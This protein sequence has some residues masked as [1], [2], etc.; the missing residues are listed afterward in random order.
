LNRV[1]PEKLKVVSDETLKFIAVLTTASHDLILRQV[2]PVGI[3]I[4]FL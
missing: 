3:L 4:M 2:N 1:T